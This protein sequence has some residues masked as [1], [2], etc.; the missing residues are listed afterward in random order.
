MIKILIDYVHVEYENNMEDNER[1]HN[2]VGDVSLD[3]RIV[4]I[5]DLLNSSVAEVFELVGVGKLVEES[6]ELLI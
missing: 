4:E 6:E 3:Q 1:Q 2:H 5:N